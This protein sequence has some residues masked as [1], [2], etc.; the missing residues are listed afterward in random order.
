MPTFCDECDHVEPSSRKKSPYHWIC[1]KFP[2][3]EGMGFVARGKWIAEEPYMH[4]RGIN[5][6]LCPMWK[7]I[8]QGQQE[9]SMEMET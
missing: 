9:L 2:R 4:C 1:M 6:G 3:V 7:P 5:G 8:R